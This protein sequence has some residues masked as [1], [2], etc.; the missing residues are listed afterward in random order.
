MCG[1][2]TPRVDGLPC[3]V[4]SWRPP[5]ALVEELSDLLDGRVVTVMSELFEPVDLHD[6]DLALGAPA[7][8]PPSTGRRADGGRRP[9]RHQPGPARRRDRPE[10]PARGRAG[11]AGRTPRVGVPRARRASPTRSPTST[12]P[13]RTPAS[14]RRRSSGAPSSRPA[15]VHWEHGLLYLDRY[16][17]QETQ[18]LDDLSRARATSAPPSTP[19]LLEQ[20]LA[21]VFPDSRLRRAARGLPR[22][23]PPR[24]DRDHRRAGHRQDD[25]R[26]GAAGRRCSS[27]PR[28]A[29][30]PAHRPRRADRQGR[31][32]PRAGG[33]RLRDEAFAEADQAPARRRHAR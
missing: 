14:G 12:C 8:W 22:A 16:H 15:C 31:R 6:R 17:E 21:R 13:G 4:F 5:V 2:A 24:D 25:R 33:P 10:R 23:R 1:P 18:V 29:A 7:P 3:G 30:R 20:S 27:R 11:V 9:R 26:G 19:T 32:P 28:R